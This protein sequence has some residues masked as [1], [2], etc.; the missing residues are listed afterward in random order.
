MMHQDCRPDAALAEPPVSSRFIPASVAG[1]FTRMHWP[2]AEEKRAAAP[3]ISAPADLQERMRG[4]WSK[5][6][7]GLI[8]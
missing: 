3:S 1:Y 2:N 8:A 7:E 5:G 6:A 4:R